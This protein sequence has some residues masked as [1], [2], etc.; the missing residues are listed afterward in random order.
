MPYTIPITDERK[1]D[2]AVLGFVA[3]RKAG[4][5]SLRTAD[6]RV[7]CP[8]RLIKAT[9]QTSYQ[10]LMTAAGGDPETFARMLVEGD[11]E[12]PLEQLGGRLEH[13][14][15]VHVRSD[16]TVLYAARV[17]RVTTDP[18]GSERERTDFVDVEATVGPDQVALPWTGK[19]MDKG[20]VVH[21]FALVRKV[22]LR[23]VNGLTFDFLLDI[24]RTL[25]RE[26]KLL[27]LGSGR[28]GNRPLIFSRNGSSYHGFLEGRVDGDAYRLVVHLSDMELKRPPSPPTED[29]S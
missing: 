16:G 24:A 15:R 29:P 17:L 21:R 19:L 20:E 23:H 5:T 12:V 8:V 2:A 9:E 7:P 27:R 13:A 26:D 10:A 14:T 11:P 4:K 3:S 22:Q 6:G 25:N 18:F 28:K 1:R